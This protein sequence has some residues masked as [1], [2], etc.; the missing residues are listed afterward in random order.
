MLKKYQ[1]IWVNTHFN[2]PKELTPRAVAALEKL[3]DGGLVVSNQSVLLRGVNDCAYIMKELCQRLLMARV[4]PYKLY[5]CDLSQGIGHFRTSVA[6]GLGI[7][8]HLVG[9]TSGLALPQYVVD[10]PGGGGKVPVDPRY[11]ISQGDRVV[12]FRN[13][14]GKFF[15]YVEPE[16]GGK[17][18]C[19]ANCH[20]CEERKARG[21]DEK[22]GLE[23]LLDTDEIML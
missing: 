3:A 5:Q 23:R 11:M 16:D 9:H 6:A 1:P 15:K 10:L 17:S 20:I 8:E 13:Y 21:L 4:R 12:I 22:I 19:P 18:Q 7:M 2:H 14:A